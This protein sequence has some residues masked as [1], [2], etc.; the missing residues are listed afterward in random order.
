MTEK[1]SFSI[2]LSQLRSKAKKTSPASIEQLD[3]AAEEHGFVARAPGKRRG[4]LP[5]PRTGQVHAKVLPE[6]S[7]EIAAEAQRR[8]VTQGVIVEEAWALYQQ[9]QRTK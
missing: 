2:D 1:P 5:S 3:R 6:V 8:G 9:R 4:R 7:D